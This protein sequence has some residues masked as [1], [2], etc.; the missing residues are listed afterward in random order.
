MKDFR[1][2]GNKT[3]FVIL[4]AFLICLVCSSC[5]ADARLVEDTPEIQNT[6]TFANTPTRTIEPE[7]EATATAAPDAKLELIKNASETISSFAIYDDFAGPFDQSKWL[8][9]ES[10]SPNSFSYT[11]ADG[12]LAVNFDDRIYQNVEKTVLEVNPEAFNEELNGVS[13]VFAPTEIRET[14]HYGVQ[15]GLTDGETHWTYACDRP[16]DFPDMTCELD[17]APLNKTVKRSEMMNIDPYSDIKIDLEW[18]PEEGLLLTFVNNQLY[19]YY[20]LP[21]NGRLSIEEAGL[22][23]KRGTK[24]DGGDLFFKDFRLGVYQQTDLALPDDLLANHEEVYQ[25]TDHG[26]D[27]FLWDDFNSPLFENSIDRV[28]W[29]QGFHHTYLNPDIFRYRNGT[30][31]QEDGRLVIEDEYKGTLTPLANDRSIRAIQLDLVSGEEGLP[32]SNLLMNLF[33]AQR[34]L[35]GKLTGEVV[36]QFRCSLWTNVNGYKSAFCE[37]SR[38]AIEAPI[39][40]IEPFTLPKLDVNNISMSFND[41]IAAFEL[42]VNDV[43]VGQIPI[44][45]QDRSIIND[46]NFSS[47]I[48]LDQGSMNNRLVI[49]NFMVG[50]KSEEPDAEPEPAAHEIVA[51]L[52]HS[53]LYLYDDFED[54]S[55]DGFWN[56]EKWPFSYTDTIGGIRQENGKLVFGK[57]AEQGLNT[58]LSLGLMQPMI[59]PDYDL[60][61][62]RLEIAPCEDQAG[63]RTILRLSVSQRLEDYKITEVKKECEHCNF[64]GL[65]CGVEFLEDHEELWCQRQRQ[66]P[67]MS[68]FPSVQI[69]NIPDLDNSQSHFLSLELDREARTYYVYLDDQMLV[70]Y[71]VPYQYDLGAQVFSIGTM[72]DSSAPSVVAHVENVFLGK[73]AEHPELAEVY[74]LDRYSAIN[75]IAVGEEVISLPSGTETNYSI[76]ANFPHAFKLSETNSIS[77]TLAPVDT[78]PQG[79]NTALVLTSENNN[80]FR[81]GCMT[82]YQTVSDAMLQCDL[83]DMEGPDSQA[84]LFSDQIS[85]DPNQAHTLSMTIDQDKGVIHVLLDRQAVFDVDAQKPAGYLNE[86]L[87]SFNFYVTQ[88]DVS[89]DDFVMKLT[90]LRY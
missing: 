65:T 46:M 79:W 15:I 22:Y 51:L 58:T 2:A 61:A 20:E 33:I 34:P 27:F 14:S 89:D 45:A 35:P 64:V 17:L 1:I 39:G 5:T 83:F 73:A 23:A 75:N 52:P 90:D 67:F 82:D 70:S 32:G 10:N 28:H 21:V 69:I 74:Q 16:L 12:I 9:T 24:S 88:N 38:Q 85:F 26:I 49:D 29:D 40:I 19:D 7:V 77:M 84:T 42:R 30:L 59:T 76:D 8:I 18:L 41:S 78:P 81:F 56:F 86:T 4:C 37:L 63:E 62:I 55:Y 80:N 68:E 53:D 25:Y 72:Y 54:A 6:P 87:F 44:L 48:F 36:M 11:V 57:P 31:H 3:H 71:L 13:V 66:H 50:Y 47:A 60:N 43:L